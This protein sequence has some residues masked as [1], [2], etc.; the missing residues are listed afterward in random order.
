M[1]PESSHWQGGYL[2]S[3]SGRKVDLFAFRPRMYVQ[4]CIQRH[5]FL[6]HRGME[7]RSILAAAAWVSHLLTGQTALILAT[8]AIAV[9]GL[10]VMAG[11]LPIRRGI[12]VVIGIFLIF[13][14]PIVAAGLS[15]TN[16]TEA[17]VPPA[18]S[19]APS[20]NA[21]PPTAA[22]YDPYAGA[23]VPQNRASPDILSPVQ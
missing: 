19:S 13:G 4:T 8:V 22:V 14:A 11:R 5:L 17:D 16:P 20:V 15:G 9:L 3:C 7:S 6:T 1:L 10:T 23:S 21:A 12:E 18:A 2:G